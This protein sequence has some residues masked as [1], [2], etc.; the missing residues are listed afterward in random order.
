MKIFLSCVS[1]QFRNC[2]DALASDL[3]AVGAQVVVQED[4]TMHGH[5][6]LEKLEENIADC[7]SFITLVGSAYGWEPSSSGKFLLDNR[8]SYTQWEY[9]FASGF[10]LDGHPAKPKKRYVYIA[11]EKFLSTHPV[12]Q[13]EEQQI[14]QRSFIDEILADGKDHKTFDSLNELRALVLRDVFKIAPEKRPNNLPRHTMGQLFKGRSDL[15]AQLREKLDVERKLDSEDP[16]SPIPALRGPGGVG[17]TRLALEFAWENRQSFTSLLFVTADSAANLRSN[18]AAL[19]GPLV[20][21]LDAKD[22]D[23]EE[24][25]IGAVLQWL[26][27]HPGWFLIIDNVDTEEA[28]TEVEKLI[29]RLQGGRVILTT[30]IKDWSSIVDPLDLSVL[31]EEDSRDY[32]LER[33]K[34]QRIKSPDDEDQALALGRELDGLALALVQAGAYI[35]QRRISLKTYREKLRRSTAS[36]L[37]WHNEVMME[38]PKSVA[39]TWQ[40]SIEQVSAS[41]MDLLDLLSWFSPDVVPISLLSKEERIADEREDALCD[42]AEFYLVQ[43]TE[44]GQGV[45]LHRLV[46]EITRQKQ[47]HASNEDTA[48]FPDALQ[49]ALDLLGAACPDDPKNAEAWPIWM[50]LETHVCSAVDFS[51]SLGGPYPTSLLSRGLGRFLEAKAL[52]SSAEDRIQQALQLDERQFGDDSPQVARNLKSLCT[53]LRRM[54]RLK[55]AETAVRRALQIDEAQQETNDAA[56]ASDLGELGVVLFLQ[57]RLDEREPL[58]RRALALREKCFGPEHRLVAECLSNLASA[59][60][61]MRRME[62]AEQHYRRCLVIAEKVLPPDD[63]EPGIWL[64]NLASLLSDTGRDAEAEASYRRAIE[65]IAASRVPKHPDKAGSLLNL[66]CLLQKRG[67]LIEAIDY[68]HQAFEIRKEML[69]ANHTDTLQASWILVN[70]LFEA[71]DFASLLSPLELLVH[72]IDSPMGMLTPERLFVLL[73]HVVA[74]LEADPG[75][76]DLVGRARTLQTVALEATA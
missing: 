45:F 7:D 25:Q 76:T 66:A 55:E 52:F 54:G 69:G 61:D 51:I 24:I 65:I 20:L 5:T 28:A 63:P 42:L 50:K 49:A 14:L 29:A 68:C 75:T 40:T 53:V 58:Y 11:S 36:L 48:V 57:K 43:R 60:Q 32:L 21:D 16:I 4:F 46:Q 47:I 44:D 72:T 6:L 64:N 73:E 27:G 39:T 8:R 10:R 18:L 38:Y 67:R 26:S 71:R 62:E 3:R 41:A 37:G 19:T 70:L 59:L 1:E 30:R 2:R 35:C 33:T 23:Q 74:H 9:Q 15:V 56:L 17:K 31:T 12:S 13:T 34:D 22:A